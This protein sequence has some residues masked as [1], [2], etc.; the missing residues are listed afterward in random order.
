M[1]ATA[2]LAEKPAAALVETYALLAEWLLYPEEV[3]PESLTD[4]TLREA[5]AHAGRIDPKVAAHLRAFHETRHTVGPEEYLNLLEL[6]PRCPL[7]LGSHQFAEPT[8]CSRAGLSDRN[9]YMLEVGNVYRHFGFEIVA[10]LPDFLPAMTEFLAMSAE[11][12]G[13]PEGEDAKLRLRFIEKLMLPGVEQFA[14]KLAA[15]GGP[16]DHLAQALLGCLRHELG[17]DPE[18][19]QGPPAD[20]E[21][22]DLIQIAETSGGGEQR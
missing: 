17:L 18:R 8:S 19:R 2:V 6:N 9:Q 16:Y 7:Y 3:D 13:D 21:R 14:E 22:L 11:S 20:G 4:A 10:E 1:S 5:E 12:V 15:E